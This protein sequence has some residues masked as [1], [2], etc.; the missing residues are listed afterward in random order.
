MIPIIFT[1]KRKEWNKIMMMKKLLRKKNLLMNFKIV[2][3]F[4]QHYYPFVITNNFDVIVVIT[5]K[6]KSYFVI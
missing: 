1:G 4:D 6:N 3:S 5:E 2:D